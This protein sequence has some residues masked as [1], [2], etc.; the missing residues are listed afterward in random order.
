MWPGKDGKGKNKR[1]GKY[2]D[3]GFA[4]MMAGRG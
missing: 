4:R 3:S 2:R 1:K